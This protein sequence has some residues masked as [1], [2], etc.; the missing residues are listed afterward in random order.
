MSKMIAA[1]GYVVA[2]ANHLSAD[3]IFTAIAIEQDACAQSVDF[4]FFLAVANSADV[5]RRLPVFR[6][7]NPNSWT[8]KNI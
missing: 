1:C 4:A 6:S 5:N 3:F 7:L 8:T 2:A